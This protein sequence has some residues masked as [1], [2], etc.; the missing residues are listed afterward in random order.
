MSNKEIVLEA[1]G[2]KRINLAI[3]IKHSNF[4]KFR[5]QVTESSILL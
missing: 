3:S 1:K 2:Y 4:K 5:F